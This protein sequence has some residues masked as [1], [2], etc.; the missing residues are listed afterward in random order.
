VKFVGTATI[1]TDHVD[2]RW[3]SSR[4]IGFASAPGCN[5]NSVCEYVVAAL[6]ELGSRCGFALRA[7]TLG[8][9]GVGHIGSLVA[10]A[11]A[12]LGMRVLLND[13]PLARATG[14]PGYLPLDALMEA[15]VITLHVPL[16]REGED[17]TYHFFDARRL[18]AMREGSILVNASRG[19][20]VESGALKSALTTGRLRATALDVWEGEPAIDGDLLLRTTLGTP[21]IAGYSLDGKVNAVSMIY[22]AVCAHFR[23]D[24]VWHAS[25]DRLPQPE[26]VAVPAGRPADDHALREIVCRSYDIAL[27]DR[28]LRGLSALPPSERGPGF[29]KLRAGYRVR[30]EFPAMNVTGGS[31]ELRA[32]LKALGFPVETPRP[33]PSRQQ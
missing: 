2:T 16:T 15:D 18:A 14:D 1:G 22:G 33:G 20:V 4:G 31:E 29:M 8:I 19:A 25:R 32:I 24:P 30:R 7:T 12:A 28:L 26:T 11:A 10:R 9:V 5:A 3:L 17:P 13:P 23:L 21:H 6:L 27:D